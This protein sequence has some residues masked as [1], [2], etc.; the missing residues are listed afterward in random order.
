MIWKGSKKVRKLGLF[1]SMI[2]L[3]QDH[4]ISGVG[5]RIRVYS[6]SNGEVTD[7]NDLKSLGFD[8]MVS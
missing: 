4:V 2:T 5:G 8:N 6:Q 1:Q 3:G 7:S